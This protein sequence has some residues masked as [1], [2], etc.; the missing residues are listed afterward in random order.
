MGKNKRASLGNPL[1]QSK[2]QE[3][4]MPQELMEHIFD[5][6]TRINYETPEEAEYRIKKEEYNRSIM[7]KIRKVDF[8]DRQREVF[9]LM[10]RRGLSMTETAAHLGVIPTTIQ[11]IKEAIFRKIKKSVEYDF[12]YPEDAL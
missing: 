2:I 4:P 12:N 5:S 11:E 7:K 10:Y 3:I 6:S 9:E 1:L 8:T